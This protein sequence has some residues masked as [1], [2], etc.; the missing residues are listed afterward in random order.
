MVDTLCL[1]YVFT[2]N[3]FETLIN[4]ING[5]ASSMNQKN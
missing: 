1:D 3:N 5:L 4:A 2:I